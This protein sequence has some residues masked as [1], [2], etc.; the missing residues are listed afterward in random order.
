MNLAE[1]PYARFR[2]RLAG[3]GLALAM[4][5]H[6][7]LIHSRL[8]RVADGLY[9]LYADYPVI[10]D[11][12]C[13][14]FRVELNQPGWRRWFRPQVQFR[15][16]GFTPFKPLPADQAHAMFEWGVNWCVGNLDH[17]H[18]ILHAAVL[19][20]AGR[21]LVLP[22]V[23]GAGK[24]TL[25]A[26]LCQ[27]GFRLLSDELCLIDPAT[28]AITPV[29]R[30]VSLKNASIPL[31]QARY[32]AAVFSEP[33]RD[34]LKGTVAHMQPPANA[35]TL[36]N[37]PALPSLIVFPR[38]I[39]GH[40]TEW[41]PLDRHLAVLRCVEQSFNYSLHG[42]TGFDTLVGLARRSHCHSLN[43]SQLD[44]AIPLLQAELDRWQPPIATEP[45]PAHA[46]AA[47]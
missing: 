20:R 29:P 40:A 28:L 34:T 21:A 3:P 30:P 12:P 5:P 8:T 4:P 13:P 2:R 25:T 31:I 10:D 33:A 37:Q 27:E 22:G 45:M 41:L 15:F 1:L 14:D 44:E 23:P 38:Y 39:A 19:E 26:A 42:A 35:L 9:A 11:A 7:V 18:V 32:P 16:D 47:P 24:S 46:G 6:T 36:A 43:Y 17:S